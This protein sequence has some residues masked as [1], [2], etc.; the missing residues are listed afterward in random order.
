[1]N[2]EVEKGTFPGAVTQPLRPPTLQ[3]S[4]TAMR[5][6]LPFLALAGLPAAL[7]AQNAPD[8][9][10]PV[11]ATFAV[12]DSTG[13]RIGQVTAAKAKAQEAPATKV[14][15]TRRRP[16]SRASLSVAGSTPTCAISN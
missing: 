4:G 11:R 13:G 5:R 2:S 9:P 15:P 7:A 14:S 1:M 16:A 8:G 10:P 12:I 6:L 3:P